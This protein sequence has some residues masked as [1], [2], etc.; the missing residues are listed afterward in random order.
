MSLHYFLKYECQKIGGNLKYVLTE[1]AER[2]EKWYG[3]Y[4]VDITD[5]SQDSTATHLSCD[6]LLHYKFMSQ[7]AGERIFKIGDHLAKLW[8]RV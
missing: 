3:S 8:A 7:F 6:G 5:K 4:S 1:E 2:I